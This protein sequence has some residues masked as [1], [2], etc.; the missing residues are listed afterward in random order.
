MHHRVYEHKVELGIPE[1]QLPY[2]CY[3]WMQIKMTAAVE[4]NE[5]AW[6]IRCAVTIYVA[7]LS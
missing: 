2:N 4:V 7:S 1:H 3:S 5:N 6:K